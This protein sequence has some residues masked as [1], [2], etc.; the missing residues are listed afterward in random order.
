M[1]DSLSDDFK[2]AWLKTLLVLLPIFII[3]FGFGGFYHESGCESGWTLMGTIEFGKMI[4]NS[5]VGNIVF[6]GIMIFLIRLI[7]AFWRIFS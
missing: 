4:A 6:W 1:L 2:F 5:V 3:G 7:C